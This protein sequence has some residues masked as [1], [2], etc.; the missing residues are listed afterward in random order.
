MLEIDRNK[1][2][3]LIDVLNLEGVSKVEKWENNR[4]GSG[5][6]LWIADVNLPI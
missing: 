6:N 1:Y 2:Y 3:K 4:V 5:K